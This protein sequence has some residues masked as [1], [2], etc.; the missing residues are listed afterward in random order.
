VGYT[1]ASNTAGTSRSATIT[2]AGKVFT[3]TQAAAP[4]SY[5]LSPASTSLTSSGGSAE[6][7]GHRHEWVQLDGD[8]QRVVDHRH[9]W[10]LGVGQRH[11]ADQR[12]CQ[13]RQQLADW[14]GDDRR[15][16]LHGDR[17]R[18]LVLVRGL[19]RLGQ[20]RDGR[21]LRQLCDAGADRLHVDGDEQRVV[22]DRDGRR[23]GLG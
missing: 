7:R 4:C 10:R 14:Y 1:V 5:S 3:V 23:L 8:E 22:A 9:V 2:V 21:R 13:Q 19:A 11:R 20:C 6:H 12:G 18:Q 16:D 15:Q 17:S